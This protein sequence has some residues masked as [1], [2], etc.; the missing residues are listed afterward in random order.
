MSSKQLKHLTKSVNLAMMIFLLKK[1][2]RKKTIANLLKWEPKKAG[3]CIHY[4]TYRIK[5]SAGL[6]SAILKL[7]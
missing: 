4:N 6:G 1:H 3:A 2:K 7:K 5:G